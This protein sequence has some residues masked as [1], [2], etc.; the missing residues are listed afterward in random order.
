MDVTQLS[1]ELDM[2]VVRANGIRVAL[3][4]LQKA[5]NAQGMSLRGDWVEAFNAMNLF[6]RK[7][8]QAIN[9]ANAVEAKSNMAKA[10]VQIEVL[11]KALGR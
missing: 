8:N 5:Q 2:M 3:N 10:A 4:Q 7:A 6:L 1:D 11:E 9:D